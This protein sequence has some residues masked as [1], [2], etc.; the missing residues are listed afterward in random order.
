MTIT[1]QSEGRR[2]YLTGNT[3]PI[4]DA[5]RSAGCKWDRDRGAWWTGKREVA[6]ALVSGATSGAIKAKASFT[7]LADGSWG[8]LVHGSAAPGTQIE[9]DG[10]YGTKTVTIASVVE[11]R[12]NGSM[13]CSIVAE[14]RKPRTST[15]TRFSGGGR[16]RE[17]RGPIVHARHHR[18][19]GGLCGE[20]A[21]D[22]YDC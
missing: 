20:C 4:K 8:V 11:A 19:M 7:K 14:P 5:I 21:F 13:A 6:E 3:Y 1:I 22:E 15:G 16:C 10:K 9:V 18:A 2:H 12:G 17:C